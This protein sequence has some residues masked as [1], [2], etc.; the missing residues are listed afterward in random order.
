[1]TLPTFALAGAAGDLGSRIARALVSRGAEVRAL[2]RPDTAAEDRTHLKSL[3]LTL[4]PADP[5]DVTAMAAAV[6]GARCVVSALNGLDDVI[7]G[8][9]E[10]LL[11]AAVQAG[12]PRFI[13]SDYSEEYTRITPGTNRNLDLRREFMARADRAPIQVTSVLNGAFMDLLGAEMPII[14]PAIHRVLYWENADQPLDFTT[15]DDVAAYVAA[16]ALDDTTP[17]FLRIAGDTLS[18]RDLAA[19]MTDVTGQ[20]YRTLC[21][22]GLG[23]LGLM[24]KVAQRVAPQPGEPF[25]VWQGMQYMRDMFSGQ[26][27]LT[28]LDNAR[29][30]EVRWTS[31]REQMTRRR[32]A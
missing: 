30:P 17:R 11:H 28:P 4:T 25:P 7:L 29:Y 1:M 31:V 27:K 18:A 2:I 15:K 9:Q 16:A 19:V 32:S 10:V 22:G 24:I 14:Q 3:G 6:E 13:P 5:N 23:T 21:A 26:G 8:R 12:V 20:R